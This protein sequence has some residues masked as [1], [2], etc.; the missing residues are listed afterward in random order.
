MDLILVD[1]G[2]WLALELARDQNHPAAIEHWR[3]LTEKL[4]R[5]VATSYIFDEVVTFFNSRGYHDKA[6]QVGKWLLYSPSIDMVHVDE[7]LFFCR[8]DL[9][10]KASR[11]ELFADGLHLFRCHGTTQDQYSIH[12]RSTLY[13]SRI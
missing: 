9:F 11:Q 4:P 7:A 5:L 10:S 6:V 2:Y 12:L 8:L 3:S 1:T 13:A